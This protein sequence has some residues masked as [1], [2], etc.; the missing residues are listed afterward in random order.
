MLAGFLQAPERNKVRPRFRTTSVAVAG[1]P[2]LLR[3]TKF[4]TIL[5]HRV[6]GGVAGSVH[7]VVDIAVTPPLVVYNSYLYSACCNCFFT[8]FSKLLEGS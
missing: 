5:P 2:A 1:V 3:Q 8:L 4:A 6:G 7:W